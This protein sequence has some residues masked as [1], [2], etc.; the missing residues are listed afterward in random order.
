MPG[1][2]QPGRHTPLPTISDILT[3]QSFNISS[4]INNVILHARATVID[5]VPTSFNMTS[6]PMS[7]IVSLPA[8]TSDLAPSPIAVA[9]VNTAPFT[10]THPNITLNISGTVLPLQ[11][12]AFPHLSQFLSRYLSGEPNPILI[13]SSLLDWLSLEAMFPAP[14]PRPQL[15][16]NVTIRDMLIKPTASGT[17]LTSGTVVARIVL[18]QGMHVEVDVYRVFPD[19]LV[20]DGEVPSF[21]WHTGARHGIPPEPP[22]PDPLPEGAFGHL[23]PVDWLP[24]ISVPSEPEDG[25][26]AAYIV[27]AKVVDV[28]LQV[29][30]GRQKEF[31]EFVSKVSNP[32]LCW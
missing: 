23:R 25:E 1:L 12:S 5:P 22:L 9:S 20:F 32:P 7:F 28:P 6:P 14:N 16:R 11:S 26:G 8:T 31:R 21:A 2:P 18:P 30:P 13:S 19:V 3:L 27:S 24:S 17:F 10:L 29:L 4:D 15:L